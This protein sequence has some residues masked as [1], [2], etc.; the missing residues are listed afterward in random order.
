VSAELVKG[1]A[2]MALA[3]KAQNVNELDLTIDVFDFMT[4]FYS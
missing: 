1:K 2:K 3:T 4:W